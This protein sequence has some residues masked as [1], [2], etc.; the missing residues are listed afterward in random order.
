MDGE[1]NGERACES[2]RREEG[3]AHT[4]ATGET[5]APGFRC[6]DGA[7]EG[8]ENVQDPCRT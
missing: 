8:G 4:T 6:G 1:A 2:N 7:P 5:L 3:C